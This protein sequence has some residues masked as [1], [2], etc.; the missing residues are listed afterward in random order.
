MRATNTKIM[1]DEPGEIEALLP[2]YAAGTLN[3]HDTRRV[4]DALRQDEGLR[5]QYAAIQDEYSETVGLNESLGAPSPRALQKLMAAI[6]AEPSP[7]ASAA[8]AAA[9]RP[10]WLAGFFA[11]LSPRTLAWSASFGALALVVQAGLIGTILMRTGLD[12]F[13]SPQYETQVSRPAAP[14]AAPTFERKLETS[15][16]TSAKER[17]AVSAP[18]PS[19]QSDRAAQNATGAARP[20]AEPSPSVPRRS[21]VVPKTTDEVVATVTFRP[22]ARMA[23]ISALLGSYRASVVGSENGAFR[24]RF[25]GMTTP[26]DLDII[27]GAL[28]KERIV[29]AA[30]PAG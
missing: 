22:E 14:S 26:S 28:R 18:P 5:R 4:E 23:D 15:P 29:A 1:D 3:A 13:Q 21:M 9:K 20:Q 2:W 8:G 19:A 27:L 16:T 25:E 11:G 24:L 30:A 6:D 10:G 17:A 12:A 7:K